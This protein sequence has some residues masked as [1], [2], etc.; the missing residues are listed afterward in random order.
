M[1]ASLQSLRQTLHVLLWLDEWEG[2]DPS[3]CWSECVRRDL[4][5]MTG[6]RGPL[7][8]AALSHP[9]QRAEADAAGWAREAET[10]LAAVGGDDF[11]QFALWWAPFQSGSRC[12]CR[13]PAATS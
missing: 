13:S 8:P 3:R 1:S 12:R 9:R 10:L 7:A 2:L 11:K 5:A 4:R 6:E